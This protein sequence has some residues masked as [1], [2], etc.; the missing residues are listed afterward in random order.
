MKFFVS[1]TTVAIL[2]GDAFAGFWIGSCP[3]TN[4]EFP[5]DLSRYT[6]RWYQLQDDAAFT[7]GS[8]GS[9]ITAIY[10]L[11]DDGVVAVRNSL[12]YWPLNSIPFQ[13]NFVAKCDDKVGRCKVYDEKREDEP[14]ESNYNVVATDYDNYA[15]IYD[16]RE[17]WGGLYHREVSFL[18]GR[19]P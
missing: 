7:V 6:G 9:C 1:L 5:L 13:V 14:E 16:C 2:T 17:Y 18:L 10:T 4:F 15:V 8:F 3:V 11:R 19:E 12:A